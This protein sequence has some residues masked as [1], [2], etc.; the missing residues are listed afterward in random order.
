MTDHLEQ[1]K[2]NICPEG[3]CGLPEDHECSD[4]W[5]LIR[6]AEQSRERVQELEKELTC[7]TQGHDL[8]GAKGEFTEAHVCTRCERLI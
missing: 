3:Y 1:L 8:V 5:K 2:G 4:I 7:A 6:E